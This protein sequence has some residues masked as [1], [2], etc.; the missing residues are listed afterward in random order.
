[1]NHE[2]E[3]VVRVKLNEIISGIDD[4]YLSTSVLSADSNAELPDLGIDSLGRIT[5]FYGIIDYFKVTEDETRASDWKK[6]GDVFTFM[7]T[8]L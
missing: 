1:M 6:L 8:Y 5:L 7:K 2:V 3:Q 4:I